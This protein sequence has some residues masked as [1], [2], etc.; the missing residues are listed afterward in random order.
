MNV[1]VLC[2]LC[3]IAIALIGCENMEK[4]EEGVKT[5]TPSKEI[6]QSPECSATPTPSGKPKKKENSKKTSIPKETFKPVKGNYVEKINI[7]INGRPYTYMKYKKYKNGK[8]RLISLKT[9]EKVLVIPAQI[10]G[11]KVVSAGGTR[12]EVRGETVED[13]PKY[14]RRCWQISSKKKL[15]KIIVEEGIKRIHYWGFKGVSAREVILPKS[16]NTIGDGAFARTE[17]EKVVL[18]S[19]K[20]NLKT[21]VFA[22]STL[23]QIKLPKGYRGKIGIHC[24]EKSGITSFDWPDYGKEQLYSP[25]WP[26]SGTGNDTKIEPKIFFDCKNLKTINFPENQDHIYIPGDTFLG[27]TQLKQLVFPASTKKVTYRECAY[28]DNRKNGVSTLVFKGADTE[29][30]GEE[31]RGQFSGEDR[32]DEDYNYITVG[33]I[34]APKNSKAIRFAKKALKIASMGQGRWED[35]VESGDTWE[36]YSEIGGDVKLMPVE[37]EEVG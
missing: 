12:E 2:S 7:T 16:L 17:V 3:L 22:H 4:K 11:H 25:D 28:I 6:Q 14:G 32:G 9:K 29:L 13:N 19:K 36:N 37:Y 34:I 26:Y 5:E 10:D 24:F 21:G 23:K 20:T 1:K 15:E 8:I 27:C 18:K 30:V 33:K 31:Y 35:E